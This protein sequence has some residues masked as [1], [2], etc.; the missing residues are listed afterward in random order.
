MAPINRKRFS[1]SSAAKKMLT[2]PD[3]ETAVDQVWPPV[4]PSL[5]MVYEYQ[6]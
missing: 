5:Q 4:S 1:E 2:T 6:G 3:L